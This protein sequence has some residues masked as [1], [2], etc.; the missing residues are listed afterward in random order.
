[1]GS[2]IRD[3][4]KKEVDMERKERIKARQI[5]QALVRIG[6][7]FEEPWPDKTDLKRFAIFLRQAAEALEGAET[8]V[9]DDTILSY[10]GHEDHKEAAPSPVSLAKRRGSLPPDCDESIRDY[11]SVW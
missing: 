7:Q 1:L 5:R 9:D 8:K 6:S 4:R 3:V 11:I 2:S 10:S